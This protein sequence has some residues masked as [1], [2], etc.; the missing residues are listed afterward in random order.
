MP[1]GRPPNFTD[2]DLGPADERIGRTV[3]QLLRWGCPR[4]R[5]WREV[6]KG[7]AERL[8]RTGPGGAPLTEEAVRAIYKRWQRRQRLLLGRSGVSDPDSDESV[9][10]WLAWMQAPKLVVGHGRDRRVVPAVVDTL[11]ALSIGRKRGDRPAGA[12]LSTLVRDLL[13]SGGYLPSQRRIEVQQRDLTRGGR[14]RFGTSGW[15]IVHR[16]AEK[17][18]G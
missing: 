18:T 8:Q 4:A 16:A 17:K 5:V 10:R 15:L 6:A 2:P 7:A 13:D 11:T 14:A 3:W 1:G 12:A 9:M